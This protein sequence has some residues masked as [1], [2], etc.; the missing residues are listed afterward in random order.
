MIIILSVKEIAE[1]SGVSV[2]TLHYY[3]SIGLLKPTYVTPNGYRQ[4][5]S[6]DVDKLQKI[7]LLKEVGFTLMEIKKV[8][9][10]RNEDTQRFILEKQQDILKI[11]KKRMEELII[12]IDLLLK[13]EKIMVFD[14][15]SN[16]EVNRAFQAMLNKL[17][18]DEAS[19]Y[20]QK[21]G[22]TVEAAQERFVE[23]F[24]SY[25]GD[26][27]YYM[28]DTDMERLIKES[29]TKEEIE[30]GRNVLT[31]LYKKLG[32]MVGSEIDNTV[33]SL[34]SQIHAETVAMFP[35][36]K[37]D[38]LFQEMAELYAKDKG[39]AEAF[40]NLYGKGTADYYLIC[41]KE[42]FRRK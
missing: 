1:L 30:K 3:D 33:L 31:T 4:Y 24:E 23:S 18:S 9:K 6:A 34:I 12:S 36:D 16:D 11:R 2:R 14:K 25:E 35:V 20:I 17:S 22:G 42:F 28:G 41:V 21:N 37:K 29:P 8:M 26:L 15:F 27:K 7:I 40:D 5:S 19:E 39:A 13:G 38:E 10:N 32:K